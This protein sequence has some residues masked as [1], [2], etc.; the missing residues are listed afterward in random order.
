M[1]RTSSCSTGRF[2]TTERVS[3]SDG[4]EGNAASS[5]PSISAD[6]LLAG[7]QMAYAN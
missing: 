4:T 7:F 5:G 6:G 1:S 3:A 2:N